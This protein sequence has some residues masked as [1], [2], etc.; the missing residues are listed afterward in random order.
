M[1]Q[2]A[3]VNL[4]S[5]EFL[6]SI[7]QS[8]WCGALSCLYAFQLKCQKVACNIGQHKV[9]YIATYKSV[10]QLSRLE[11]V[12]VLWEWEPNAEK[13]LL[14]NG[15]LLMSAFFVIQPLEV[16]ICTSEAKRLFVTGS[17]DVDLLLVWLYWSI[18]TASTLFYHC[19]LH[20][21]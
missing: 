18:V 8:K 11:C 9:L 20:S 15:Q 17:Y 2:K 16:F 21:R 12:F 7:C 1:L 5:I 13:C 4:C 10:K 6:L 3:P 19:A 14:Q